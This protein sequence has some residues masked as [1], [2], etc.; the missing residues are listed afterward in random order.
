MDGSRKTYRKRPPR[1]E[2]QCT[3]R[4]HSYPETLSLPRPCVGKQCMCMYLRVHTPHSPSI[5]CT[6][7]RTSASSRLH[8]I[9]SPRRGWEQALTQLESCQRGQRLEYLHIFSERKETGHFLLGCVPCRRSSIPC[10]TNCIDVQGQKIS[11]LQTDFFA[12]SIAIQGRTPMILSL[13][14]KDSTM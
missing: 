3:A 6:S 12:G 7:L 2:T 10:R 9:S 13:N 8:N 5:L 14:L 1:L 11:R 4:T